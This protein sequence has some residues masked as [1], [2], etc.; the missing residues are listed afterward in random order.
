MHRSFSITSG[1]KDGFFDFDL[2]LLEDELLKIKPDRD[3]Y[4]SAL[5][6]GMAI[7]SDCG[8]VNCRARSASFADL[9]S[10]VSI[11]LSATYQDELVWVSLASG[12]RQY[13]VEACETRRARIVALHELLDD[14]KYRPSQLEKREPALSAAN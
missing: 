10:D 8:Y 9:M 3:A 12:F 13:K 2:V 6:L 5:R 7:E 14:Q 11:R 4:I 1:S